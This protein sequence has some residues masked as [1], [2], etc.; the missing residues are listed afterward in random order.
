MPKLKDFGEVAWNFVFSIYKSEW[1]TVYTN[2]DNNSFR[3]RILNKFTPKVPKNNTLSNSNKPKN[4]VVEIARLFL[5]ISAQLLKKVLEKSNFFGKGKKPIAMIK[6]NTRQLYAQVVNP[7][8]TNILKLKE[9]HPN[10]LAKNIENI[11]NDSYPWPTNV[12]ATFHSL[13]VSS[14]A[15]GGY[16]KIILIMSCQTFFFSRNIA[17]NSR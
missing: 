11:H 10:L 6:I 12:I 14:T 2:K 9:D 13:S 8:V 15:M 5:P 16:P 7:K 3:Y 4:K 17:Y 1:D